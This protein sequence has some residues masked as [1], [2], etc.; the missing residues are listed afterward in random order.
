MSHSLTNQ[1]SSDEYWRSGVHL[2]PK[3]HH[4]AVVGEH[5]LSS[6]RFV[7]LHEV[8]DNLQDPA[9][10]EQLPAP[11]LTG[12]VRK[13]EERY[14]TAGGF[15]LIYKRVYIFKQEDRNVEMAVAIKVF[16]G[17]HKDPL[18][19]KRMVRRINREFHRW[20]GL[21]HRNIVRFLGTAMVDATL[22]SPALI[23]EFCTEGSIMDHL[24]RNS[25]V[26]RYEMAQ[27]IAEGLEYLNL[28]DIIH[29]DLKPHNV[30]VDQ[31]VAR[32]CD[33]GRSRVIAYRG[34]TTDF[35]GVFLYLAPESL[36]SVGESED[37]LVATPNATKEGDV[38]SFAV[39]ILEVVTHKA[40]YWYK[41][42][43]FRVFP[44]ILRGDRP[45]REKY[46]PV[47]DPWRDVMSL[48]WVHNPHER[49]PMTAVISRLPQH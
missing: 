26:N 3:N 32:L 34:F 37:E 6:L 49:P 38:Y 7:P 17:V 29:G 27:G 23:S 1:R 43:E 20:I 21:A 42:E 16:R 46:P 33:F 25:G 12:S 40:P 24:L 41:A 30:L 2:S 8:S 44:A 11:D 45:I 18:E 47:R 19:L 22:P 39:T 5:T 9:A 28:N 14:F 15:S 4:D 48:C 10:P 13:T 36:S 31:G 35:A